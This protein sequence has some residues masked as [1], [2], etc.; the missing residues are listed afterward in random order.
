[1]PGTIWGEGRSMTLKR[2][3]NIADTVMAILLVALISFIVFFTLLFFSNFIYN[4]Q[5][6]EESVL[7][8]ISEKGFYFG[9]SYKVVTESGQAQRVTKEQFYNQNI[10]NIAGY[11]TNTNPFFTALDFKYELGYFIM[12][13]FVLCLFG[14]F[15]IFY[16]YHKFSR[17]TQRSLYKELKTR[18]KK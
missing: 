10:E 7:F 1:M 13:L 4:Q 12:I 2:R 16:F 6:T 11:K 5:P 18:F 15:I 14:F 8:K 3:W 9:P 17:K